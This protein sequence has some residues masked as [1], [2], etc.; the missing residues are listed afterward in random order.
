MLCKE[1]CGGVVKESQ[2]SHVSLYP[3][4]RIFSPWGFLDKPTARFYTLGMEKNRTMTVTEAG[5]RGG[6]AVLKKYGKKQLR[7]WGKLG[8][9]P[10]KRRKKPK[11]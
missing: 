7:A 5:R 2:E 4:S 8:G 10:P 9:R 1:G 11:R 3:L 6:Q